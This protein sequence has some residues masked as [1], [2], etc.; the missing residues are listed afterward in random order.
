[1]VREGCIFSGVPEGKSVL[2]LL[3]FFHFLEIVTNNYYQVYC[4]FLMMTALCFAFVGL[5]SFLSLTLL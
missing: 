1:M 2:L 3:F 4:T 5:S